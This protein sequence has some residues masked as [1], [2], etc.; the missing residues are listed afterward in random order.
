MGDDLLD[1]LARLIR[2]ANEADL[3]VP[4]DVAPILDESDYYPEARAV[5]AWLA[6][7]DREVAAKAWGEG[8]DAAYRMARGWG[9]VDGWEAPWPTNP[10]ATEAT[11]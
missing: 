7:H 9:H 6:A 3:G 11:P 1:D 10:Y 8:W 2:D 4:A 5:L